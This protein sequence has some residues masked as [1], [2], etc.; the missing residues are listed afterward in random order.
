ME[1]AVTRRRRPLP[2]PMDD[3]ANVVSIFSDAYANEPGID[4]NPNWGQAT[5]VSEVPVSG[6]NTLLYSGLD[7]QGTDFGGS[8]DVSGMTHLHLDVWTANSTALNVFLISGGP[9][10]TPYALTVPTSGWASFDIPLSAFS[11]PVDLAD[12][13]QFKFDGN[14]DV[15]LDNIY[16]YGDGGGG[17]APTQAAPLPM[18]DPA[19]VVSIF[20]DAYANEPGIDLNPNWGQATVVSEVPVSG[21][22]T[23]LYSGLDYQGTDF[24]GSLDVSGMTHLHLDV[25]TANSTALNV[26]LI[27]GGPVET[28]Y[29]LTVP[30]SGWASFDIPLSAFSP[31]VDLADVI[32]FKFDGNGDVYLDN[33]YFYGDGGGGDAPTQ[34]APLPMDDPANVVSIFSDAYANEPGIDLNPNWGQATVVSEVPVSGDNTLLYSGLDYQGTD[35]GGS[36][37]V[38]GMTHLH[39]D[40]WTANSTA[41]NVFLIS[42]GPVETPYALTV[43]TSGWASF[44]IPL[45]AFSPPVDLADVIQFKFDGNGDV[46]L[47][48]I[49]FYGDG[50]GGDAPTQAAPLPMDDPANVVSIFSDAYA[51]EPGIDL[52]PNWGQATV[53]S[54]VPVSGDNTLLYSGLDY[55]GTDFGGSL[56]VSGMTHLHLDVWTANSTALNVFLISGGPV[57]TPYALTVPTS[58]WASFDIPLSAFSPP[59]DLADVIQFKFD[60]NGDVYLDNIYFYGDGGGG[61]A[62]TQAAPLPMDDP[63]NVVSIFSDAYANEPGIDLNPNWGQATVVS[64]VPVSGDNTLLYSGLDYQGT[65]FGG[66]LDVS[67]MTHLHLDVWTANSTAL[68]VFLISGGP[69]E[70]PYALTVPTSGWASFDIPLSAFSPP[71]DLADVIQFKFDGNGDVYLDNIYFYGDGGG[72]NDWTTNDVIDFE[73][74]GYGTNW[75]WNVFENDANPPLEFVANPDASGINTSG[76]VAKITALQAGQP[77]AG[78][79]TVHGD[80]G[81]FSFDANNAIVRIMVYKSVISDVGLKFVENSGDAQ[82][83]IKMANTLINE[84]EELTFDFSGSI[85]VGATG[86][87]DQ[88]VVFPDFDLD[89]RTSNNVMYFDNIRFDPN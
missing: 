59:V 10:E 64:E 74:S 27:S 21:D 57:E 7:Y 58:G 88:I 33:I 37:D 34:A 14:G 53:V 83:E 31:P 66:S 77:W 87:I 61:D 23:L 55:Q 11:P 3:P 9:V 16:F 4:L 5:V 82:P 80:I 67:G 39:L 6:D 63:A 60:G 73:A 12:V 44:D 22:N 17:D 29:A 86:I 47:D 2:L 72:G 75:T 81:S 71:V 68:N 25:W 52:N 18:D 69:V 20:S 56:D 32:Q 76:T 36:L 15:Y 26:F 48:N 65:D 19:N 70:T 43:P 78:C 84:W 50:G 35:F 62:P 24:G 41:L 85:G 13:I 40:V 51:N 46:Y 79:E 42:G 54:E 8:L 38:S 45:S 30:T 49:Y 28:P 89:G 1:E